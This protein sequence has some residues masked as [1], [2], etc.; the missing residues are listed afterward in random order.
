MII[1]GLEP[2]GEL[3]DGRT[4]VAWS[5]TFHAESGGIGLHYSFHLN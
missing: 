5:S 4:I 3:P 2:C 1:S